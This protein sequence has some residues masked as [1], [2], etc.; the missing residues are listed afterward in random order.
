MHHHFISSH[1]NI[2]LMNN[3]TTYNFKCMKLLVSVIYFI[4]ILCIENKFFFNNIVF[5]L[6]AIP[7]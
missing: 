4:L 3:L 5:A 6:L 2:S 7:N 1:D